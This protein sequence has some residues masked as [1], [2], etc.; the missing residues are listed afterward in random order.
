MSPQ[1]LSNINGT[2]LRILTASSHSSAQDFWA[3]PY[4]W[5]SR[6]DNLRFEG[7]DRGEEGGVFEVRKG[8]TL[9]LLVENFRSNWL[10]LEIIASVSLADKNR[11]LDYVSSSRT[12]RLTFSDGMSILK[13]NDIFPVHYSCILYG[14]YLHWGFKDSFT[15]V[16]VKGG[17]ERS[18]RRPGRS[19]S[20]FEFVHLINI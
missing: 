14:H 2:F 5:T 13:G 3:P 17:T 4:S 9:T 6:N 12:N 7:V 19:G 16:P 20:I 11:I 8:Q 10:P 1:R 18:E 15:M